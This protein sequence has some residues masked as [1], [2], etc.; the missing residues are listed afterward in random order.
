MDNKT[1]LVV[2]ASGLVGRNVI[3]LLLK[4]DTYSQIIVLARK[5]L[6]IKHDKIQFMIID[7]DQLNEEFPSVK[8]DDV[9]CCLGTTIKKAKTKELMYK[10]DVE[11]PYKIASLAQKN[12]LNHFLLVSAVGADA[13]SKLFYSR[14]KGEL[15][16]KIRSLQIPKVS[17]FRPSLLVG[18][19]EEFRLGES[20]AI[21]F[22]QITSWA[23]PSTIRAKMGIRPSV[24]AKAMY[25]SAIKD[26]TPL[27]IYSSSQM[28]TIED[29]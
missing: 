12:G 3:E 15:E 13:K 16:D 4:K 28:I 2:G 10:I 27:N 21:K 14:I 18:D 25:H 19:R 22:Y 8:V 20:L 26:R 1:A 29:E 17:I 24:V 7:F 11:Y 9:Y 23:F 5:P 6:P